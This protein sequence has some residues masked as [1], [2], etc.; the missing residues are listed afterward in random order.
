MDVAR[1]KE[2]AHLRQRPR[3]RGCLERVR[4]FF[5]E[6]QLTWGYNLSQVMDLGL[7]ESA[8]LELEGDA[9]TPQQAQDSAEVFRVLLLRNRKDDDI[10]QI[11][12]TDLPTDA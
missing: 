1:P 9:G 4:R 2:R 5:R 3:E 8:L 7:K 11:D 12:E 6:A 10:I